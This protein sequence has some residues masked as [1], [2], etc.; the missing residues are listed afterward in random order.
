MYGC[1]REESCDQR[2]SS[3]VAHSVAISARRKIGNWFIVARFQ[4]FSFIRY[5]TTTLQYIIRYAKKSEFYRLNTEHSKLW[6]SIAGPIESDLFFIFHCF[7]IAVQ[8]PVN[9]KSRPRLPIPDDED[10]YSI[11]GNCINNENSDSSGYS[12]SS[13]SA[14]SSTNNNHMNGKYFSVNFSSFLFFY[15]TFCGNY[16]FL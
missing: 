14:G 13:G 12:G 7:S 16:F 2:S 15:F 3:A 6:Q 10:P 9:V 4:L 1:L 5:G 8:R 11:A